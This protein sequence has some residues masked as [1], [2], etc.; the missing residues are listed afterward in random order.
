[1]R[2]R[3]AALEVRAVE[4]F[5]VEARLI[6][7]PHLPFSEDPL[8]PAVTHC[9]AQDAVDAIAQRRLVGGQHANIAA[10]GDG[11]VV[12]VQTRRAPHGS[13]RKHM[14]EQ[15]GIDTS[16]RQVRI[17]MHVIVVRDRHDSGGSLRLEEQVVG[18]RAA[19][20]PNTA[21]A[22]I[23]ERPDAIAIAG[24][25]SQDFAE[26]VVGHRDRHCGSPTGRVFDSAQTDVEVST[27]CRLI[28][29]REHHLD[30]PWR[31]TEFRGDELGNLHVEAFELRRILWVG[32]D[33]RASALGVA[34]PAED[35]CGAFGLG[36]RRRE[37]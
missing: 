25:D 10:D 34:A 5:R 22:K 32:F 23:G 28:Q 35:G 15:H 6:V 29:R 2:C 16:D 36:S 14:V 3:D 37:P 27:S 20:G 1:M 19:Q 26:L 21:S 4:D 13:L 7:V 18:D 12:R 24:A 17:G 33:E 8:E 30:K 9:R 11:I 31:S